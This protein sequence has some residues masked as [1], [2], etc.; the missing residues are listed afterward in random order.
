M[1]PHRGW[2]SHS[3][4]FGPLLRVLYFVGVVA[5]I[6]ALGVLTANLFMPLDP[7]GALKVL[8]SDLLTWATLNPA[9]VT[10]GIIGLVLGGATHTL[11][12]VIFSFIKRRL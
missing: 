9:P 1:V 11:A 5:L 4:I 10:Y 2:I 8:G 7:T 3:L 12:D 6:L